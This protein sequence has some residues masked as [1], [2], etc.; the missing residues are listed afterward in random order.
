M[1]IENFRGTK[2]GHLDNL[3]SVNIFVGRNN[4]G[5]STILDAILFLQTTKK[6]TD[7][8]EN[9]V[10]DHILQRRVHRNSTSP[11]AMH[12]NYSIDEP[13]KFNLQMDDATDIRLSYSRNEIWEIQSS[14]TWQ[15]SVISQNGARS[16]DVRDERGNNIGAETYWDNI[17]RRWI[18]RAASGD[19]KDAVNRFG[20]RMNYLS[21]SMLIDYGLSGEEEGGFR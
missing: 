13:I 16:F 6:P 15:F 3:A 21:D 20:E 12:Y 7:L 14:M 11:H 1:S 5:K 19:V 8:L 17:L 2:K 10:K 4:T 18:D 9:K